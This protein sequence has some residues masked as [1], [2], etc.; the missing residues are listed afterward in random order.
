MFLVKTELQSSPIHGLGVFATEFI[1]AGT[2]VWQFQKDFDFRI[3]EESVAALPET[4]RQK[5]LHYSAKWGGGYVV[6]ADDARFL[7]HSENANLK[8]MDEPD[9]DVAARDIQKGEELLE[10][11]REFDD[12][13]D[14]RPIPR[15]IGSL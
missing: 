12:T 5:L 6:S 15:G 14:G 1:P 13:F 3:S 9:S 11:Y 8:T 7:N 10:D 2:I 4:A